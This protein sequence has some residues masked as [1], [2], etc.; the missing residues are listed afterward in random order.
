M[1]QRPDTGTLALVVI[2]APSLAKAGH[3]PWSRERYAHVIANLRAAGAQTVAFDVDFSAASDP[4]SDQ[5]LESAIADNAGWIVLPTFVQGDGQYENAPMAML[6]RN[7]VVGSV[8][9]LPDA[10]GRVRQYARGFNHAD[11]YHPTI[12]AV[13]AHTGYGEDSLFH[14]DFG[15]QHAAIPRLSFDSVLQNAF[16]PALVRGRNILLGS[17]AE[18][19]GDDYPTSLAARMPG[20]MIHALAYESLMQGRALL[21][22]SQGVLL[23]VGLIVLL[24]LWP[25]NG[26]LNIKRV[27]V[28]HAAI[29]S[30]ALLGPLALQLAAPVSA[31]TG[32][33][34]LAQVLC[35]FET[36]RRELARR[37]AEIAHQRETH[38]RHIALHEPETNLPN[39]RAMQ[40]HLDAVRA[41]QPPRAVLVMAVG[42]DK[43]HTLRGAIGYSRANDLMRK[44]AE[45]IA[46]LYPSA[47]VYHLSTSILGVLVDLEEPADAN[48][49]WRVRLE[50]IDTCL[51]VGDQDIDISIRAG[52]AASQITG[53][54]AL[55]SAT[56]A[57]DQA[58]IKKTFCVIDELAPALDPKLQLALVNGV[59]RGL[60]AGQFT[61]VY[62]P[63]VSAR[64]SGITGAEAL[65]RWRHPDFGP[66]S[67]ALFIP[68]AEETGAILQLTRWM[69]PRVLADQQSLRQ[70][71][72]ILP[73][74][75]NLSARL[76]C[77][78]GF[79][80]EIV[81]LVRRASASIIIEITETAM[82]DNPS[83]ALAGI[84]TLRNGGIAISI[85]DYGAGMSSLGYLKQIP[86]DE[87]KIDRS[88]ILD[89][90]TS[91]RDRLILGSTVDLAHSLGM[92]VVAEGVEDEATAA[93][94]TSLG[95]DALQG[96]HVGR[97]MPLEDFAVMFDRARLR[98]AS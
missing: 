45:R 80:E 16:D 77:D 4:I 49:L 73:I 82:L 69:L 24:L 94:L 89:I 32:I 61:I 63:K 12:A 39:R 75:V 72:V 31:N 83:V 15:I 65:V 40:E 42:V 56:I 14:V 66:I 78:A 35:V 68:T 98:V 37:D 88:L 60:D 30:A 50:A 38:L 87:L 71:G 46:T 62:Q 23:G 25:Q 41:S 97:P 28:R 6:A 93:V 95:C 13:L 84:D 2:D 26:P 64:T 58:R 57:L 92:K 79:C 53:E 74:A 22:P 91:P 76:L 44:L 90:T 59:T 34:F 18:E 10:D 54:K 70:R 85:D 1:A 21:E 20:V 86:A 55:E 33:V 47:A 36:I 5:A 67:P 11:H 27:F 96:H 8:N 9:I 43:F 3:W 81:R 48:N 17:T 29:F 19:L 51:R 7:A 52:I